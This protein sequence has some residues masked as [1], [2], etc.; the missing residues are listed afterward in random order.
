MLIYSLA[1]LLCSSYAI[2]A[3]QQLRFTNHPIYIPKTNE[4]LVYPRYLE[5]A[6]GSTLLTANI[7][8][9]TTGD[10]IVS[11]HQTKDNG[12][13][14]E[15]I[16]TVTRK[17]FEV[18]YIS[19]P[20]LVQLTHDI[21]D[22]KAGTILMSAASGGIYLYAS[23]DQARTWQGVGKVAESPDA[24]KRLWEP[25]LLE[26]KGQL[27]L[28]YSDER[29]ADHD[30]KLSHQVTSDLKTWGPVVTDVDY[31]KKTDRPGMTVMAYI[32]PID[33][34]I[35]VYEFGPRDPPANWP[36]YYRLAKSP[37]EFEKSVGVP[38]TVKGSD[39]TPNASPYVV[40]TPT[41]GT[42]GTI[43][44]VTSSTSSIY[45]NSHGGASDQWEEHK[46][47]AK[48]GYAPSLQLPKN[49]PNTVL[50]YVGDDYNSF[51]TYNASHISP[52]LSVTA[53]SL[54]DLAKTSKRRKHGE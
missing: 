30:Q 12:S 25:F 16:S 26:Y 37:L 15:Q 17:I 46:T 21:G 36:V 14:W 8:N 3:T 23:T 41:G 31:P 50:L 40:W 44:V 2:A 42:N 13:H 33:Q 34:W 49:D 53:V 22:Y 39:I 54:L 28:Y 43:L 32:P 51:L 35:L 52:P 6:D 24:A 38:L 27:V 1:L 48:T 47:L 18:G 19:Q 45:T 11:V 29:D 20:I 5:L 9:L 7:R 4:S 10:A